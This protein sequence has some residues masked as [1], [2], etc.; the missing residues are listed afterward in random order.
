MELR[1]TG[2]S[3]TGNIQGKKIVAGYEHIQ[4]DKLDSRSELSA[5]KDDKFRSFQQIRD[6]LCHLIKR[7]IKIPRWGV[8]L[9][10]GTGSNAKIPFDIRETIEEKEGRVIGL[11]ITGNGAA[12]AIGKRNAGSYSSLKIVQSTSIILPFKDG[13]MDAVTANLSMHHVFPEP[14]CDKSGT[15]IQEDSFAGIFHEAFRVLAYDGL[16]LVSESVDPTTDTH[17][18]MLFR[19]I[20]K[21]IHNLDQPTRAKYEKAFGASVVANLFKLAA[22][23][24]GVDIANEPPVPEHLISPTEWKRLARSAG[25]STRKYI[26]VSPALAHFCFAKA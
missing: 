14:F 8:V 9:D 4:G 22:K 17:E 18:N 11:E 3:A 1:D 20:H 5:I 6:A 26:R 13:S 12:S 23:E 10:I 19:G 21:T 24:W 7:N 15:V 25:F 16:F 2:K